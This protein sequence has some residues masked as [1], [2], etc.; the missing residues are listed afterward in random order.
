MGA[1]VAAGPGGLAGRAELGFSIF[2]IGY[3]LK[4]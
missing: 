2:R 3:S 4:I 1:W